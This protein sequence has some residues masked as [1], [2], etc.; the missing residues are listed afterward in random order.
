MINAR[1]ERQE[2]LSVT[3]SSHNVTWKTMLW[4]S[5]W[6]LQVHVNCSNSQPFTLL[7]PQ[8]RNLMTLKCVHTA[9]ILHALK[10]QVKLTRSINFPYV[11]QNFLWS[12]RQVVK[13][14]NEF[15]IGLPDQWHCGCIFIQF[16]QSTSIPSQ[17]HKKTKCHINMSTTP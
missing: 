16:I 8:R 9:T 15:I 7:M 2:S 17:C 14:N 10:H 3:L 1:F 12:G 4:T 5:K 13:H 11:M 6:P